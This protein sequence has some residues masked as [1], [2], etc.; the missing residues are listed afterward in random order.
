EEKKMKIFVFAVLLALCFAG[1][2]EA[3]K[4]FRSSNGCAISKSVCRN[5]CRV[6]GCSTRNAKCRRNRRCC[7]KGPCRLG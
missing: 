3:D 7:C 1:C 4:C 2:V 6:R 5:V